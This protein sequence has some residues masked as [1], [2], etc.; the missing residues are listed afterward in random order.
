MASASVVSGLPIELWRLILDVSDHI[1]T[2]RLGATCTAL[3]VHVL[4][5]LDQRH[6]ATRA[7]VDTLV[8]RWQFL[9]ARWD[10][11]WALGAGADAHTCDVCTPQDLEDSDP[12]TDGGMP[13]RAWWMCDAG[14]PGVDNAT[15]VCDVCAQTASDHPSNIDRLLWPM[16]RVDTTRPHV[17]SIMAFDGSTDGILPSDAVAR[18]AVPPAA[19]HLV[20]PDA[21]AA[22]AAW[23][24]SDP[25]IYFR[26]F[27]P[28]LM[29]SVRA[30]MP[31][32]GSRVTSLA[33]RHA[34]D[35]RM[36]MVCCDAD[37]RMWGAV[38]LVDY[39]CT[40]SDAAWYGLDDSLEAL[41]ARHRRLRAL[42]PHETHP[43]LT[44]WAGGAYVDRPAR[45][46]MAERDRNEVWPNRAIAAIMRGEEPQRGA[47]R[48]ARVMLA[49][50]RGTSQ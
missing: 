13:R 41:M 46:R 35:V 6:A 49:N 18:F 44:T 48:P 21:L 1:T 43:D 50:G 20:D 3:R 24:A 7:S 42:R 47:P 40:Y 45:V 36:L 34:M 12:A 25:A 17:W 26:D 16:R 11:N 23:P 32:A 10:E 15:W 29:P 37:S 27:C 14:I 4:K 31:L 9:A 8:D 38:V 5:R 19:V 30:W 2:A 28:A 33:E 22:V 39:R